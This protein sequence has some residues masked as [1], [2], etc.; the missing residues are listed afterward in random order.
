MIYEV[1]GDILLSKAGA[2]CHGIAPMDSFN[3]GLALALRENW[4]AM[5]NDFRH[6]C[7]SQHPKPG[8][9]WTW[10]GV[11][12]TIIVNL[13]TQEPAEGHGSHPGKATLSN[14]NHCFKALKKEVKEQNIKSLAITRLAT[15]VG[16]LDWKE[17]K[18]LMMEALSDIG[19]PVYVYT[20]Y[21]KGQA[22]NEF[23]N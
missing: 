8:T 14:L 18:P 20:T 2:I 17:V 1:E 9:L 11:N 7:H 21:K 15:G 16:G 22:A 5:Y 3:S 4:P 19:I 10:R 12:H 23:Q 13:F 6:Y